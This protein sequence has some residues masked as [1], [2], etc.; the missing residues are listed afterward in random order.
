MASPSATLQVRQIVVTDPRGAQIL[1]VEV[2][3]HCDVCGET[4]GVIHGHHL[5]TLYEALG[6]VIENH[7]ELCGIVGE[8]VERTE[9]QGANDPKKARY[10]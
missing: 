7:P 3:I 5:R 1:L 4:A 9:F 8:T 2:E 6:R 10:N